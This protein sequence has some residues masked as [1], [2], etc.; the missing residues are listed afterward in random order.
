MPVEELFFCRVDELVELKANEDEAN[1]DD[2]VEPNPDPKVF[3]DEAK[4]LR[5]DEPKFPK[6]GIVEE[7]NCA[8][9]T[10]F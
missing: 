4:F 9:N 3:V 7:E 8:T 10:Y 2:D 6:L 5:D 1:V